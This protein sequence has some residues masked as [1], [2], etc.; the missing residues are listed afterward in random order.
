VAPG[1]PPA[2]FAAAGCR[3]L[4]VK[5]DARMAE[6]ARQGGLAAEVATFEG[7]DP[8]GRAFD[9]VIAGQSWHWVE[10]V[11]GA[12]KAAAVLRLAGRLAVFRNGKAELPPDHPAENRYGAKCTAAWQKGPTPPWQKD[13]AATE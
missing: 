11:A 4:G 7:W 13:Q 8:A 12:G 1:S 2:S 9:A 5:P 10:P 6:W 3:V